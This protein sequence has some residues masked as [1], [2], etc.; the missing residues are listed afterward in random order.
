MSTDVTASHT[1]SVLGAIAILASFMIG[2][3]A[4][5]LAVTE[6][7]PAL[8]PLEACRPPT[9]VR[10][11]H[12]GFPV[13]SSAL[14]STGSARIT[15]IYVDF[16][17]APGD[18]A[19]IAGYEQLLDQGGTILSTQSGD[20]LTLERSTSGTWDRLPVTAAEY[21]AVNPNDVAMRLLTDTVSV[22]DGHVDFSSTDVLWL[23]LA[24]SVIS[25]ASE[26]LHPV[27]IPTAEGTVTRAIVFNG[28]H[29]EPEKE[30]LVVHESGH[31]L[32]LPDLYSL[33]AVVEGADFIH[34][35]TGGWDP[36]GATFSARGRE[37][38]GW[39]LWRLGWIEDDAVSCVA[40]GTLGA[41]LLDSVGLRGHST[42]AVVRVSEFEVI[43]I[44]SRHADRY[45]EFLEETAGAL[46]Y[47]VNTNTISGFEPIRVVMP[48]GVPPFVDLAT[49]YDAV[50][51]PGQRYRDPSGV[52]IEA[53]PRPD[54]T[55]HQDLVR[56]DTRALA[57]A[58]VPDEAE[59][60]A[61]GG[62]PAQTAGATRLPETGAR[63]VSPAGLGA[64]MLA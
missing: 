46:I 64:V 42:I 12:E 54:P 26:E 9:F 16:S 43:V 35:F 57:P 2:P 58:P 10:G 6:P 63:D 1:F 19:A 25:A 15:S 21:E 31:S 27:Q 55:A 62:S 50:L 20:R 13:E 3:P 47:R 49:S 11:A 7:P 52:L 60:Q 23:I 30:W 32:G 29:F 18:P 41:V 17:D 59:P 38:F 5:A 40:H 53:L 45:D 22:V 39:H 44:E 56:I 37:F 33:L 51:T 61:D 24:P 8:A 28:I 4:T 34:P 36:M 14:P 48:D